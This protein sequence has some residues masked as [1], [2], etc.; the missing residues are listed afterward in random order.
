VPFVPY[1]SDSF[2]RIPWATVGLIAVNVA[3]A[4]VFGL[5]GDARGWMLAFGR[6]HPLTWITRAF[7]HLSVAHLLV[8]MVFLWGMGFVAE[9]ILGWRRFLGAVLG[10]TVCSGFVI[11]VMMLGADRGA[12]A[13]AS[14]LIMGLG[15]LAS[16]LRP[17]E[18]VHLI[19]LFSVW[20]RTLEIEVATFCAWLLAF[21]FIGAML[22]FFSMSTA[23]LHLL[24][25]LAGVAVALVMLKKE[26]I[27]TG[28]WDWIALRTGT[29]QQ[30]ARARRAAPVDPLSA[31]RR[32][33]AA[34]E[35]MQADDA[36]TAG[37]RAA[38]GFRLAD[39]DLRTLALRL[40]AKGHAAR[41]IERMQEYLEQHSDP[42]GSVRLALAL[43]Y[44]DDGR[45]SLALDT[46]AALDHRPAGGVAG[47]LE[48]RARAMVRP[49]RLELE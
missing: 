38:P 21:D 36:Y 2:D 31:V 13:G 15:T 34:N 35:P 48:E 45:P 39:D 5:P 42:D 9:G 10:I 32:A 7:I 6:F 40:A 47:A 16:V 29:P 20:A 14:G 19:V 37:T 26:W 11:Q 46:L 25:A 23:V 30:K 27:D 41:A 17:R 43:A 33:L 3:V 24:G 4:L 22:V 49:G 44:I 1:R 28:G 12:S 18:R 8:N